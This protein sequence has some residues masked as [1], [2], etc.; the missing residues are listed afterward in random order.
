MA[1][2]EKKAEAIRMREAGASYSQIKEKLKVSKASLSLWLHEYPLSNERVRELR[3]NSPRRIER[4]RETMRLKREARLSA[5][6]QRAAKTIG[7]LSER[8][9]FIGGL[10]LY[11]GEGSKTTRTCTSISNTDPAVLRFFISWLE[12]LDIPKSRIKVYVHLY[13][14]MDIEKEM[15]FWSRT[16]KLP[17]SAFRKP[18]IKNSLQT[19]LSYPQRFSHGTCNVLFENRDVMER[20]LMSLDFIRS[21]FAENLRM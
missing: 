11:W 14:D 17:L 10:F 18:Y 3:G 13:K 1:L 9:M 12:I 4:F 2:R 8:E 16:L 21:K 6:R 5:V 15:K 7:S 19:G 20:V